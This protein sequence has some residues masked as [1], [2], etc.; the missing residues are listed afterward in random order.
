M[1]FL[2]KSETKTKLSLENNNML[3]FTVDGVESKTMPTKGSK[4]IASKITCTKG[5]IIVFDNDNW[6]IEV[7]KLETD[8]ACKIDF[9]KETGSNTVTVTINDTSKIDSTS[10]TTTEGGK[11]IFYVTEE[12]DSITGGE[13]TLTDN[14]LTVSNVT[15]NVNL[16]ITMTKTLYNQLLADKTTRLTRTN[17][18]NVLTTDNTKTL[19]TETE[20]EMPVYYF[21]GNALDNWVQFGGY[22][23]RIIRS[24]K[25]KSIRLLYHST[26]TTA[27][28]S[29]ISSNTV[30]S[31]GLTDSNNPLYVGYMYGTSGSLENNRTNENDSPVKKVLD[32]WYYSNLISY[33]KFLD[34][35]AVYC[36]D[37]NLASGQTYSTTGSFYYSSY[38][39]LYTNKTPTY[40]CTSIEDKFTVDSSTGNGKLTY[41]IALMTAD[42]LA[43]AGGKW[44][45]TSYTWCYYNSAKTKSTNSIMWWTMTPY[46]R[47]NVFNNVYVSSVFVYN[48][49]IAS[50]YTDGGDA[51]MY[52]RPVISLK[53]CVKYSS[54]DGSADNPYTILETSSGC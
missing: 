43:F 6:T 17:F 39:R 24:N 35:E 41:P 27:T 3:S 14:K 15:T 45:T 18:N 29:Y 16:N 10:K 13:Y 32:N 54:G 36:N 28:D 40:D 11:V 23:W 33:A 20:E 48:N 38:E 42:E 47:F 2:S 44:G 34:E 7:E 37:R 1:Y 46:G 53:S 9:S 22:Y 4:Y 21:A 25:N 30:Y 26:S 8:D 51:Y 52:A 19:Y 12:P 31:D 49:S 5:S 50:N